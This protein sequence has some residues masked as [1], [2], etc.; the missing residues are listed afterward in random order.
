MQG[1][2][3]PQT[4]GCESLDPRQ[5]S[6]MEQLEQRKAKAVEGLE[7]IEKAIEVFKEHPEVENALTAL[8]RVGIYR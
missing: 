3:L 2:C 5:M 1:D 8:A 4:V 6:V 7:Q